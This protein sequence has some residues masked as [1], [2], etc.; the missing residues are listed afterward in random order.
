[1][2]A[3]NHFARVYDLLMEDVP[4]DKWVDNIELFLK[5]HKVSNKLVVELGC[6]TGNVSIILSKKG[7]EVVVVDNFSTGYEKPLKQFK[8]K[9][10]SKFKYYETD[11]KEPLDAI[12]KNEKSNCIIVGRS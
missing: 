12:F 6:G 8:S 3:Y 11:L 4:Y 7:Y 1:M 9:Y 10:K 5:K 2:S